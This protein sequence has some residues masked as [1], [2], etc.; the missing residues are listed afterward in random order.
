MRVRVI[1][2]Q[3]SDPQLGEPG[4]IYRLATTLLDE[5]ASPALELIVLYHERW[6][7]E[8]VYDEIKTHQRQQKKVLRS[9]TPQGVRKAGV[10]DH[11]RPL[12]GPCRDAACG[13]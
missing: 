9:K 5:K 6:E 10:C 12:C 11:A 4:R 2:Y 13:G 8:L 3:V 7:I 1:E